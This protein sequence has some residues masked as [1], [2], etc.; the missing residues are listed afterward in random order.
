MNENVIKVLT[1][2]AGFTILFAVGMLL[3]DIGVAL[4]MGVIYIVTRPE[5]LLATALL[6]G[7]W[8]FARNIDP[9]FDRF[10]E[11]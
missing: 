8:L 10:F 3:A 4:V 1:L 5:L 2:L 9:S 11:K 7:T 6:I